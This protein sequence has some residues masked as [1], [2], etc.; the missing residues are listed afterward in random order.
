MPAQ[1]INAIGRA[2]VNHRAILALAFPLMVSNAIQVLLNLIDT[3][4]IARISTEALAAVGAIQWLLVAVLFVLFGSVMPVQALVGRFVGARRYAR[5][6]RV[7]WSALW[8][9]LSAAPV[10]VALGL[11]DGFIFAPFD[12]HPPIGTLASQFWFPRVAGSPLGMAGAA[13]FSFFYGIGRTRVILAVAAV[14][15]IVNALLNELFIFRF[16]WGV[17]GSAWAT[18]VAQGVGLLVVLALFLSVE[19]RRTYKSHLTWKP[20]VGL[21]WTLVRMGIPM[22]LTAAANLLGLALFQIMQVRASTVGGAATQLVSTIE[23]IAYIPGV[24]IASASTT[25]IGQSIGAGDRQWAKLLGTRA[26][27]LTASCTGCIGVALAAIGPWLLPLFMEAPNVESVAVVSLAIRLLWLA[28]A[29]EFF[30]GLHIGSTMCLYGAA[31]TTVPALFAL[32]ISWLVF[33]PL[34]HSLTFSE[35]EGWF[36]FLPHL[37]WGSIGGWTAMVIYV[38]ILGITLFLRWR[39]G[40]WR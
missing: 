31:D 12:F 3:W 37:G 13:I 6:A 38:M 39:S 26:I 36:R 4:F 35:G 17:A 1:T 28:A 21:L 18:T 34:A 29:Y 7:V 27:L 15:I 25:L 8:I 10:F 2:Q 19:Y 22:G 9:T 33:I 23:S 16:A 14:D 5:A 30:A 24:G 20:H 32:P 11:A 40:A